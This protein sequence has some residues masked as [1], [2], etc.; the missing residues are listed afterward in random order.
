MVRLR[1]EQIA[2]YRRD[3]VPVVE[4]AISSD[5]SPPVCLSTVIRHPACLA[6]SPLHLGLRRG[7]RCALRTWP[8]TGHA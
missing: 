7:R 5:G 6:A 3:G 8:V 4:D 2:Q 1:S